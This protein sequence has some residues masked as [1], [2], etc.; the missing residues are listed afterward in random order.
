M[1]DFHSLKGTADFIF[2]RHGESEGN[3]NGIMQGRLPSRLT[4][5]GRAQ[6]QETG[7]ALSSRPPAVILTSPLTRAHETALII[8]EETG[9]PELVAVGELTETDIGI[10]TNMSGDQARARFPAEWNAF[11]QGGWETVPG[12]EKSADL[13]A[14]AR[15]VWARLIG[16]AGEGKRSI[17]SVTHSGFLQWIIRV[18]M[19][20]ESWMPLI[21]TSRHCG[22]TVL[23][24]DNHELPGS[25]RAY[26]ANWTMIN[27]PSSL[28]L[29]DD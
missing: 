3:K 11:L 7:R 24:V 18:T 10:F 15:A 26:Y 4:E 17:L 8:A 21:A 1:V 6:A 28:A 23:H 12:A 29:R 19:G 22:I 16:L 25:G 5:A 2:T 27:L 13:A 14:R 9:A 20:L